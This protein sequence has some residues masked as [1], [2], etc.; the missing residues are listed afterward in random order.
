[1]F[2]I[3]IMGFVCMGCYT[4]GTDAHLRA[5]ALGPEAHIWRVAPNSSGAVCVQ[6][7]RG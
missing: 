4:S 5:K 3:V 6:S 2:M 1:M 7:K